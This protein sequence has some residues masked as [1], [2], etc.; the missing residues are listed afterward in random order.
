MERTKTSTNTTWLAI[1][2]TTMMLTSSFMLTYNSILFYRIMDHNQLENIEQTMTKET[3]NFICET[4][5]TNF[6]QKIGILFI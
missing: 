5:G 3:S 1:K 6:K 2:I 4:C